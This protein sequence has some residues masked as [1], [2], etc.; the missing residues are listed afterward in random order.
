[1]LNLPSLTF[2]LTL[3]SLSAPWILTLVALISIFSLAIY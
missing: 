2:N 1:M 3:L